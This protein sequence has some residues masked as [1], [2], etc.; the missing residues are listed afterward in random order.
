MPKTFVL[1]HGAFHGG[2]CW[3]RVAGPLRARGHRVTTPTQTGLGE[4]RHLLSREITL[5]TF[6]DD[7]VNHLLYEDLTDVILVGHSFGGNALSGAAERLSERIAGL[8]YLDSMVIKGGKAPM[9]GLSPDT[10]AERLRLAEETSGG[11]SIPAPP[12]RVFGVLDPHDAAWLEARLTPHPLST[13]RSPLPIEG[14]PGNGLPARYITCTDPVYH[15]LE[16]VRRWVARAGWPVEEIATG[17]DA[18]VTAPD[19]LVEML[20]RPA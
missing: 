16:A 15:P 4:R 18:M 8:V 1:L 13:Y 20:D 5:G 17:H 6:V 2:W 12:A 11:L 3:D 7:L 19:A 10:V 14:P 9:D